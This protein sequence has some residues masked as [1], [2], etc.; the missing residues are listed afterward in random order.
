MTT[1]QELQRIAQEDARLKEERT[2]GFA[3]IICNRNNL[4][5]FIKKNLKDISSKQEVKCIMTVTELPEEVSITAVKVAIEN[6]LT[7]DGFIVSCIT[8]GNKIE[9]YI[10]GITADA[11]IS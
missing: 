2:K 4:N 8:N 5:D 10:K 7:N 9:V 3:D 1:A 11:I 6:K